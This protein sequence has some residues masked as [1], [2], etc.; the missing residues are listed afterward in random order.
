[1][2]L[3][4]IAAHIAKERECTSINKLKQCTRPNSEAFTFAT[5]SSGGCCDAI[6]SLKAGMIPIWGTEICDRKR[7][8]WVDLTGTPDMG[9]TF[10]TNL[11]LHQHASTRCSMDWTNMRGLLPVGS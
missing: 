3:S 5:F 2:A 4:V 8:A 6:A 7:R 10:K 11:K 9:D 1:M